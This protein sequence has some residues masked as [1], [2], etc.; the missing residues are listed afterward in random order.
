MKRLFML[1]LI[2]F[3]VSS[4]G[5]TIFDDC[6]RASPGPKIFIKERAFDSGKVKQGD[7]ISHTFIVLNQGDEKLLIEKVEPG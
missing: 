7:I 6:V 3:M 2:F 5:I 4:S 1:N